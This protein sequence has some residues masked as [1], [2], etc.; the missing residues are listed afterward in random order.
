MRL[1]LPSI[2]AVAAILIL[3]GSGFAQETGPQALPLEPVKD[4]KTVAKGEVIHHV[5]EIRN[6]GDAPLEITDVKPACGCTVAEFDRKIAPGEIGRIETAVKTVNFDGPIAKSIAVFTNDP[7]N[8]KIQLVV[9]AL[10]QPYLAS[11]PGFARYIFVQGEN[12]EPISQ[13]VWAADGEDIEILK[14]EKPYDHLTV[15]YRPATEEE[16]VPEIEG[17]QWAV[18]ILLDAEAPVGA[19]RDY[20][21]VVT[22]HAKQQILRIPISGFVRPRQHVTPDEVD[23]AIIKAENLPRENVLTFT[24]FITDPIEV[25]EIET[26][27]EGLT[28]EVTETGAQDGH[29]FEVLLKLDS[30]M[31]P[32]EFAG[33][34]KLHITDEKNP[35]VKIPVK[36]EI[37]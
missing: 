5:F 24:N 18:D 16:R 2:L 28:A 20:V 34:V 6:G 21:E 17:K 8:P 33:T 22:N 9:K 15:S 36:G 31:K 13:L 4:F 1:R 14:V 10:V 27:I 26:D 19:L 12:V 23:F 35:V 3:A 30:G 11:K 7:N 29:R 25:N 32:G 37:L